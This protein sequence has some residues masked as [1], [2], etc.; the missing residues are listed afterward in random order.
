MAHLQCFV[1]IQYAQ[2]GGSSQKTWMRCTIY[3]KENL[4]WVLCVGDPA[5]V[6]TKMENPV[7]G[8]KWPNLWLMR[9]YNFITSI[10]N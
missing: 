8:P 2:K 1:N 7:L 9:P 5:E 4:L 10:Q 6:H 3:T